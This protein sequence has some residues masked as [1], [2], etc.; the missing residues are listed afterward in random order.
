MTD[1]ERTIEELYPQEP[2]IMLDDHPSN[3]RYAHEHMHD[4]YAPPRVEYTFD[5]FCFILLAIAFCL[6]VL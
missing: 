2:L 1:L 3:V 6:V 4:A 5:V